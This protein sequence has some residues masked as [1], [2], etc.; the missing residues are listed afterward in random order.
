M[1]LRLEPVEAI[2]EETVRVA[3]AA[4][5]KVATQVPFGRL[6]TLPSPFDRRGIAPSNGGTLGVRFGRQAS[7][8]IGGSDV[9]VAC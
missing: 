2:P 3:R 7:D 8:Q 5:P 1:S 6:P 4:F 9:V